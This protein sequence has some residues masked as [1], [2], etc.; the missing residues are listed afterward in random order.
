MDSDDD[1]IVATMPSSPIIPQ[2]QQHRIIRINIRSSVERIPPQGSD[3]D[4]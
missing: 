1:D 4:D 2:Q 3:D